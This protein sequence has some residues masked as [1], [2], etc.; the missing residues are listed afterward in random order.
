MNN[1]FRYEE[2][3]QTFA[4]NKHTNTL[5]IVAQNSSICLYTD[6]V[7]LNNELPNFTMKVESFLDELRRNKDD[8]ESSAD[9]LIGTYL[10]MPLSS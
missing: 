1:Y 5:C 2:P 9:D 3:P 7:F 4:V 8:Y 10:Y 6:I